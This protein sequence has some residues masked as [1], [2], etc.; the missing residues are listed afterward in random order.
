MIKIT[1]RDNFDPWKSAFGSTP[2]DGTM[3]GVAV[4]AGAGRGRGAGG[5]QH[6]RAPAYRRQGLARGRRQLIT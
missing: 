4:A 6:H 2:G 1:D 3:L 5:L